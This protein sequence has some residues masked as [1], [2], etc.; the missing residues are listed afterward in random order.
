MSLTIRPFGDA[1]SP[2]LTRILVP[3]FRA[4]DAYAVDPE[5]S[6]ADA[7]SYWTS[8]EKDTFVAETDRVLGTYYLRPNQD[9]GGAHVCNAGFVTDPAARGMGVASAMLEHA[10]ATARARGFRAMQFNFVVETNAG[11]IRLWERAGFTTVGRLRG[12]FLH[13]EAGY[14]DARI[15]WK[16]LV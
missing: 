6:E 7:L 9:G 5:I 13:P 16:D 12:A 14:V 10:L 11:A 2:A 15:M 1:D 8:R 3:V 4:G